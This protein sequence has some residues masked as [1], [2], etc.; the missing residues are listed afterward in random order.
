M[1]N[2]SDTNNSFTDVLDA[3]DD[4][5]ALVDPKSLAE[6]YVALWNEPDPAVRRTIIRQL[7]APAGE[8]ILD[9]P[10]EL[11]QP[12]HALGFQ[13]PQLQSRGYAAIQG[14]PL[15][16]CSSAALSSTVTRIL[17]RGSNGS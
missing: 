4:D 8:H 14:P 16:W 15:V 17:R 6:R 1:G 11:R 12:A 2:N 13:A 9:P 3:S 5:V 10:K 7:W